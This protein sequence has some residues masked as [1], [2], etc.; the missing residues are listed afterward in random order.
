[1]NREPFG[2]EQLKFPLDCHYRIIT[3]S[4]AGIEDEL[5]ATLRLLGFD[6]KVEPGNRSK[7]GKYLTFYVDLHIES[8]ENMD[9]VDRALRNIAG[10]RMVL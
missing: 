9:A 6:S 1:M 8:H 4:V 7:G 5:A 2:D 3:E 10:V